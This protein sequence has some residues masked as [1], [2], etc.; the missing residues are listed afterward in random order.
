MDQ[1]II[2]LI[3]DGGDA[4]TKAIEAMN[5]LKDNEFEKAREAMKECNDNILKAHK[6]Q[7]RMLQNEASGCQQTV[8]LLMVHAQDHLMDAMVI[9]DIVTNLIDIQEANYRLITDLRR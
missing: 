1:E 8:Q 3:L 9:R 2:E 7:T 6:A 5:L 4:R